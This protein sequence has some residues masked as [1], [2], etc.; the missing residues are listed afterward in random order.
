MAE[1][2]AK[3]RFVEKNKG[4]PGRP[5]REVEADYHAALIGRV[6]MQDWG[7][8]VDRAVRDA[9]KGD[10]TA[11][12]WL[13]DYIIGPPVQRNEH[14]GTDGGPLSILVTYADDTTSE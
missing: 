12:K 5:P 1:R 3:G 8:I 14:T 6:S 10:P 4:G 11:R 7:E 2:D 9:K 13:S